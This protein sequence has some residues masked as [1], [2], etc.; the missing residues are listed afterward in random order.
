MDSI[1]NSIAASL[2]ID[3]TTLV[4]LLGV[5]VA[6]CNL[7][8]RV[9]P[10]DATG[11]LGGVR[12]ICKV[13]GLYVSN[14]VISG[15]SVNDT[16]RAVAGAS[17]I[18]SKAPGSPPVTVK[19]RSPAIVAILAGI[20]TLLLSGCAPAAIAGVNSAAT[21]VCTSAPLAQALYN[22]A[23]ASGDHDRVNKILNELQAACPSVLILIQTVPVKVE[24]PVAP[25]TVT[26]GP[27]RG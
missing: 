8:G 16:A 15:V 2:G 5:L 10:D 23:V 25:P 9:I 3:P 11:W 4:L 17:A 24:V 1:I 20:A 21:A 13:V 19:L 22:S 27:E 14:R 7:A 26:P 12:K 18:T 6:F